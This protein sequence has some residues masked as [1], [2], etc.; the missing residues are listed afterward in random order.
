MKDAVHCG[1]PRPT[2]DLQLTLRMVDRFYRPLTISLGIQLAPRACALLS[3][4]YFAS[5]GV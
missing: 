2:H 5:R 3:G 4:D 1:A